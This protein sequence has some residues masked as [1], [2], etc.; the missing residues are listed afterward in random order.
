MEDNKDK[1][2]KLVIQLLIGKQ[3][4]PITVRRDQEEVYR[5]AARLINEKLG[6]YEQSYPNLSYERYTSVA[7]LDFAVQVIQTQKQ[8]DQSPYEDV[9]KR[10]T[11]E[12]AQ[13]LANKE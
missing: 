5:K 1:K 8:K 3:V 12:I 11:E 4:Y 10:L 7:L 13:L 2:D 9:V 6:R